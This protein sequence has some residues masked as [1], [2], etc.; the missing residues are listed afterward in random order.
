MTNS[1][2]DHAGLDYRNLARIIPAVSARGRGFCDPFLLEMAPRFPAVA[3]ANGV[4][5]DP[6]TQLVG[7][8]GW[9]LERDATQREIEQAPVYT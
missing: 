1:T 9:L 6:D 4:S 5:L 3:V 7:R 8:E 2:D